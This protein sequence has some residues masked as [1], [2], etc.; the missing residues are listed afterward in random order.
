LYLWEKYKSSPTSK[1]ED[2]YIKEESLFRALHYIGKSDG[3]LRKA[4]RD[5][6]GELC[7]KLI[8]NTELTNSS[9]DKMIDNIKT[10]SLHSFKI[11]VGKIAKE[12]INKLY[13]LLEYSTK[14]IETQKN[15]NQNET[16]AIDYIKKII[17]K[18]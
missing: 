15:V 17:A 1:L 14:I 10:T 11:L 16:E 7:K 2:L 5:I 12:N 4:E 3:Q 18:N 9:I 6:I 13:L 8:Y